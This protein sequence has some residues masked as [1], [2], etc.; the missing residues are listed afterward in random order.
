MVGSYSRLRRLSCPPP[1][2]LPLNPLSVPARGSY[3]SAVSEVIVDED[4]TCD[5][6]PKN[7]MGE[8]R[9]DII[10]TKITRECS[11]G[12]F[13]ATTGRHASPICPARKTA[14]L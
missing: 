12:P 4:E 13:R 5:E 14:A 1:A 6:R 11:G 8:A 10:D 7:T 2:F 9:L 3:I